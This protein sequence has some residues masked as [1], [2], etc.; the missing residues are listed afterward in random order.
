L[1]TNR[2]IGG[3]LIMNA[4]ILEA[5]MVICFGVSWPVSILK[6]LKAKTAKGK[7]IFFLCLIFIGYICGL[8]SKVVSKNITYVVIFYAINLVM[9]SID[10][11]L[12]FRNLHYDRENGVTT[13][14]NA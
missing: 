5:M 7:S 1:L 8:A 10:I 2:Y 12:Y 9:V 4:S 14:D 13:A 6:S 3:I 11:A